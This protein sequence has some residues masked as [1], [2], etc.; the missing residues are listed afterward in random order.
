MCTIRHTGGTTGHPKGICTTFEQ[1][2]WFHGVIPQEPESARRQLVCTT[3]AHAAGLMADSTLHAGGTV[4]LLDDF[5]P[6]TVLAA[7][8][9]ERI[10]DMFLL[11]PLL[12]Q[13][14]DHPDAPPHRHLQPAA[15]D[16]RRLPGV[17]GPDSRRGTGASAR[18]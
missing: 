9:R 17:P 11:P 5:D 7:I 18:C 14:M 15:A 3:L 13:L 1:A 6:G 2:R 12:Y 4:V 10:T 16:V 8:E